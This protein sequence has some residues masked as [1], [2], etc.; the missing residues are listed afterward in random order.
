MKLVQGA[1]F[2]LLLALT[3]CVGARNQTGFMTSQE[4]LSPLSGQYGK[5]MPPFWIPEASQAT[6]IVYSHGTS[7]S[8]R[9][10]NCSPWYV[11][12]PL[13]VRFLQEKLPNTHLFFLCSD[14]TDKPHSDARYIFSRSIEIQRTLD[15][16]IAAGVM[17]ENIFLA[18]QSAGA[19]AS[20]QTMSQVGKKFNAAF[21]FAPACCTTRK[22]SKGYRKRNRPHQEE[23]MLKA[24][25]IE[26]LIFAYED[27]EFNR[28]QDLT[29]LTNA[30]PETVQMVG[31]SCGKGHSTYR[32]DCQRKETEEKI[33]R[34]IQARKQD[35]FEK[36][37]R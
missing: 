20:L 22:D 3:A 31:Y 27:D 8:W 26:A 18:G 25:R 36:A 2:S 12:P 7:S 9:Q 34:Y 11:K 30:Y 4:G 14:V 23:T 15:R 29:F 32:W 1:L 10:E 6:V 5:D 17:P 16:L 28:P 33:L 35:F 21:L 24:E 37:A 13:T 19:W